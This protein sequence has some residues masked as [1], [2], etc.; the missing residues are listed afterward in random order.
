MN[1][2]RT[3]VYRFLSDQHSA[4]PLLRL[5]SEYG[6]NCCR[7][8][9]KLKTTQYVLRTVP[10]GLS[11]C[12]AIIIHLCVGAGVLFQTELST[13]SSIEIAYGTYLPLLRILSITERDHFRIAGGGNNLICF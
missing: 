1:A 3:N 8:Q 10:G 13:K 9:H 11:L 6:D 2:Y 5:D 4:R 12:G 7:I